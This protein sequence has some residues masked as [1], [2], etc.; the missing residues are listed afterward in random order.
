[1]GGIEYEYMN[2]AYLPN[3]KK[4]NWYEKKAGEFAW[5]KKTL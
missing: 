1:M 4:M 3:S 2:F 5:Q